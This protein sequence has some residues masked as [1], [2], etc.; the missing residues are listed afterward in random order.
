MTYN[1]FDFLLLRA[2]NAMGSLLDV[3]SVL[4]VEPKQV[5][6]WIANVERPSELGRAE[7]ERRLSDALSRV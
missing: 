4:N 7:Y 3:A 5:Y 6:S 2:T 1:S